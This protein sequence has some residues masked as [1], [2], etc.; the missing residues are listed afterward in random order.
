MTSLVEWLGFHLRTEK[1]RV[2]ISGQSP[3]LQLW[4]SFQAMRSLSF[5]LFKILSMQGC[6]KIC[7]IATLF[8]A[9]SGVSSIQYLTA[10]A[11]RNSEF[12]VQILDICATHY[13]RRDLFHQW[14][15]KPM[16]Q[17]PLANKKKY[18]LF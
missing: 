18:H 15:T 13:R 9:T 14:I 12:V 3:Q 2:R 11:K 6:K 7:S 8:S 10:H 1:L 16:Y 5:M 4:H 17:W